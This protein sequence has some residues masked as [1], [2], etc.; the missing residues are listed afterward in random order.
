MLS[1]LK[2]GIIGGGNMGQ[3]LLKGFLNHG[4][5]PEQIFVSDHGR[6]KCEALAKTYHI[7]TTPEN[8]PVAQSA[9]LLILAIKPQQMQTVLSEIKKVYQKNSCLVL[10]VAAG[11]PTTKIIQS[12]GHATAPVIRAMPNTPALIQ[13]GITALYAASTVT[14]KQKQ[15]AQA[16]LQTVGQTLWVAEEALMD[17]I[18]ALSGSGPAY[19][20]YFLDGLIQ[21]GQNQGLSKQEATQLTLQT[22]LGSIKMALASNQPLKTLRAQVTSKGGTTEQ[23]ILALETGHFIALLDKAISAATQR[24]KVLSD[25]LTLGEL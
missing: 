6:K 15:I 18:T 11:I 8:A 14:P 21:A 5:H 12:L 9:D 19:F 7:N 16:L 25:Q 20:F 4:L 17:A 24:S 3:A 13:A 1:N 2:I 22:A 10:S 23:G